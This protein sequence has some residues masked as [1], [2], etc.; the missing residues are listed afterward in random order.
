M[1]FKGKYAL[2]SIFKDKSKNFDFKEL[3]KYFQPL[4]INIDFEKKYSVL[5]KNED[6][7]IFEIRKIDIYEAN[8]VIYIKKIIENL[9]VF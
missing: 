6:E 8:H 7:F 1:D 2:R 4:T 3:N 5:F 9:N